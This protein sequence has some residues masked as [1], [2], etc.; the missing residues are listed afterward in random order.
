MVAI[1][2]VNVVKVEWRQLSELN[3]DV[4]H[5]LT[6]AQ[7]RSLQ[8]LYQD[9]SSIEISYN[10]FAESRALP[11]TVNASFHHAKCYVTAVKRFHRLMATLTRDGW[12]RP[13][14]TKLRQL[15]RRD[16]VLLDAL[17]P[18]RNAIEHVDERGRAA[19]WWMAMLGDDL[20]VSKEQDG[21]EI[22]VRIVGG[23]ALQ[24]AAR[25]VGQF[26]VAIAMHYMDETTSAQP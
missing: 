21:T 7:Q 26:L 14:A 17:T 12:P 23:D 8:L 24:V 11:A 3:A 16:G 2:E 20:A 13:I 19:I 15:V 18:A 4:M 5:H 10:L 9:L 1:G 6:P 22:R 25:F